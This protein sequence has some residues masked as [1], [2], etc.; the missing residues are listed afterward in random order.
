MFETSTHSI[1]LSRLT[2]NVIRRANQPTDAALTPAERAAMI[3]QAA[4]KIEELLSIFQIDCQ[5]DTQTS[6]TPLR[7][8]KMF[9]NELMRG[10]FT[11]PP[12]LTEFESVSNSGEMIIT[13]PIRVHSTCAHHLLP[14]YGDAFIGVLPSATGNVVGLSKYD[15]IVSYFSARLQV[16]EELVAQIGKYIMERTKPSGLAV[17]ISAVHMCK[18]HR[19]VYGSHESR[20]VTSEFFGTMSVDAVAKADFARECLALGAA[21]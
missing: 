21:R 4:R 16:Q 5:H 2:G 19:G 6:G 12:E 10:R 8:A 11:E 17:R 18:T 20:M 3:F 7:V 15:R 1:D 9:V 14:I 13:G